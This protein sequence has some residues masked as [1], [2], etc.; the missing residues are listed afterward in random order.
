MSDR[1]EAED[2]AVAKETEGSQAAV[3]VKKTLASPLH[4]PARTATAAGLVHGGGLGSESGARLTLVFTSFIF[5]VILF[6]WG[7]AKVKCNLHPPEYESFKPAPLS[8]LA[9]T[10]KDGALEFHHRLAL[11]D[12]DG[13]K[14]LLLVNEG[15]NP[16]EK[17]QQACNASCLKEKPAR[18][19]SALTRAIV[20]RREGRAAVVRAETHFQGKVDAQTYRVEWD[21]KV[22]KVSGLAE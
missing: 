16:V 6:A 4:V 17:A 21:Q 19:A 14:E 13:A 2:S 3:S 9:S 11:L 7:G 12:F 5:L 20:L 8:R 18:A 10:P 22:W 15:A 1:P